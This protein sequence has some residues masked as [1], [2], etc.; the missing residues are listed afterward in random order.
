MHMGIKYVN[1]IGFSLGGVIARSMLTHLKAHQAKF[2]LLLTLASPHLGMHEIE[3][4]LV[5]M[6][7]FYMRRV[8]KV[9]SIQDLNNE[10]TTDSNRYLH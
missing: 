6:G 8:A 7:L 1:V 9:E 3:S 2:N 4:C 10:H 5:R